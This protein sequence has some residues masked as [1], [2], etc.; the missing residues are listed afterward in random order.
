MAI[1]AAMKDST[2]LNHPPAIED[3]PDNRP[4]V[5]PIYQ[6]VKFTFDDVAESERHSRGERTGFQY[7]RVS[8]PTLAQLEQT[9]AQLQGRDACLLTASGVAAVNLAMLSLC[10]Q[11]DHVAALALR[12]Q[13]IGAEQLIDG[14]A[15]DDAAAIADRVLGVL[16]QFAQ[17]ACAILQR[18]AVFVGALVG[19]G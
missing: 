16:D 14:E 13:A 15:H 5:A 10:K 19:D 6:S 7:S 18:S 17:Q 8:N 4:L 1:M 11:G 9:L 2:R 12:G 3:A